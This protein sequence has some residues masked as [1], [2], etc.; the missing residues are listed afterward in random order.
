MEIANKNTD[1]C[2]LLERISALE[3]VI[4]DLK[5]F[6]DTHPAEKEALDAYRA[7]VEEV[8]ELRTQ[9][10]AFYGPLQAENYEPETCWTWIDNP[11]PWDKQ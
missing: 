7:Y 2:K 8:K 11:W 6:L 4:A 10:T 3:F 1:K 5:L 9:Y